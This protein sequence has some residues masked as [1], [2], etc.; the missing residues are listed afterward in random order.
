MQ[1]GGAE[2]IK[3]KNKKVSVN[4]KT[5]G[6]PAVFCFQTIVLRLRSGQVT[7]EKNQ[8]RGKTA[9]RFTLSEVEGMA[10]LGERQ[11]NLSR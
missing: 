11:F 7:N 9:N 4:E 6:R 3:I 10:G 5:A 8:T 1:C 2:T